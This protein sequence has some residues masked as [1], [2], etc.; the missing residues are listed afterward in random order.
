MGAAKIHVANTMWLIPVFQIWYQQTNFFFDF[1]LEHSHLDPI[2]LGGGDF[3]YCALATNPRSVSTIN[4]S[5]GSSSA[6]DPI[7]AWHEGLHT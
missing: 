1:P 5:D 4:L 2:C 7:E 6:G 3:C